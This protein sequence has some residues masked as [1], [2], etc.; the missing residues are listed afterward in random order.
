M[1]MTE[2]AVV[3]S[4]CRRAILGEPIGACILRRKANG[5]EF[6][7]V[8][9][10]LRIRSYGKGV[11]FET[12]SG[13]RWF[14]YGAFKAFVAAY[15]DVFACISR[16]LAVRAGTIRAVHRIPKPTGRGFFYEAELGTGDRH[17]I[18]RRRWSEVKCLLGTTLV[19]VRPDTG[20]SA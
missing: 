2:S 9:S 11:E 6:V 16:G 5:L 12:D 3:C 15:G 19:R 20:G 7:P 17:S 8:E 14:E 18:S 10:V 13:D 1:S 4:R